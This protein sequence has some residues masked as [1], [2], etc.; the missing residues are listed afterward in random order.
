M[1]EKLSG[2]TI[3]RCIKTAICNPSSLRKDER[4]S[5]VEVGELVEFR[6]PCDANFRTKEDL[7]LHMKE[8][9]F[10][11]HFKYVGKVF[12]E[13]RFRN[14]NKMAHIIDAKLY[15]EEVEPPERDE[16]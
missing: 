13:V 1:R 16:R 4:R 12:E 3:W 6:Y 9:D 5:V 2:G 10:L 14:Q 7:Y 15:N 11:E 8:Q